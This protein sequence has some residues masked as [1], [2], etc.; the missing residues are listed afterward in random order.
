MSRK[1]Q[2]EMKAV[3][4]SPERQF[5]QSHSWKSWQEGGS[6]AVL[7]SSHKEEVGF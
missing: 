6:G 2:G 4:G 1:G 7:V 5:R 3:E